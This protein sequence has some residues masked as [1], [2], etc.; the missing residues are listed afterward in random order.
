MKTIMK[1]IIFIAIIALV[2]FE[3][4]NAQDTTFGASAGYYNLSLKESM[5]SFSFSTNASGF[6]VGFFADIEV[7]EPFSIQPELQF[8]SAYKEGESVD[9]ILVPIMF[10]YNISSEFNIHAGPQLDLIVSESEGI[11]T[12]GLSLGF[13]IGYDISD[14]FFIS[15][16]YAL[17]LTN[18][19]EDAP[20]DISLK[21]NTFQAGIGYRF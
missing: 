19:L 10:K 21:F 16:N 18:R 11:N 15:T 1:K 13:G 14:Q 6:Y 20:S 5:S 7:G 9:Q 2:S 8:G 4:L 3:T 12:F 17:G